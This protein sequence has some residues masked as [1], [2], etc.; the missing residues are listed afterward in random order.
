MKGTLYTLVYSV[1]LGT[2][3]ALLLTGVGRFTAP[4][5]DANEQ[6]E[7]VRNVL[8]VLGVPI[9]TGASSQELLD[10]FKKT[11]GRPEQ[12][13]ELEL[14]WYR[15]ADK[16][17]L[18]VAVPFA[19]Q[20]LW[21]PVEGYLALEP[22]LRTIRDITFHKQ[23]ET[24]GLGGEIAVVC[25]CS[26]GDDWRD[27]VA[28]F[29]HQ[30]KGKKIVDADG[31]PGIRVLRGRDNILQ[32]NEVDGITGATMTGDKVESML[33]VVIKRVIKESGKDVN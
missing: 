10:I 21:G 15:N 11:V 32:P 29:R 23:E 5:R 4:Y 19:G 13:G 30:F 3:C 27:C 28:R 14:Y 26:P 16:V 20:G 1:A 6:A 17:P 25:V 24:P 8:G 7:E 33:N 9:E 22:D 31:K 2:V 18:A 12:R